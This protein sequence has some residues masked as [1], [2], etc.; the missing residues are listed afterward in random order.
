VPWTTD[1]LV[2]A[3]RRQAYLP[4]AAVVSDGATPHF[5]DRELLSFA[6]EELQSRFSGLIRAQRDEQRILSIDTVAAGIALTIDMPDRAMARAVRRVHYVDASG[7][8]S[9]PITQI[10]PA[11]AWSFGGDLRGPSALVWH[12]HGDSVRLPA[13]PS[14]GRIRIY[15]ALSLPRMVSSISEAAAIETVAGFVATTSASLDFLSSLPG[16]RVDV[17]R[18]ASPFTPLDTDLL[19]S[20][21]VGSAI[22]LSTWPNISKVSQPGAFETPRKDFIVLRDTTCHPPLPQEWHAALASCVVTRVLEALGDRDA[23]MF[24]RATRDERL[25]QAVESATPRNGGRGAS[26]VNTSSPLRRGRRWR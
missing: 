10:E 11:D 14:A 7:R 2:A 20:S 26:I 9:A 17:V 24:S 19:V 21:V 12:F 16:E 1:D 4:D 6:D 22:T 3:I 8:E 18:G 5:T 25:S 13:V 23:V 15:Y